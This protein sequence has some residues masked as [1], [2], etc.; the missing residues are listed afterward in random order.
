MAFDTNISLPSI[1]P[2]IHYVPQREY[3]VSRATGEFPACRFEF[4]YT[5][6]E[7]FWARDAL[8]AN[9]ASMR[10]RD[11]PILV[12]GT[13]IQIRFEVRGTWINPALCTHDVISGLA[14]LR[15]AT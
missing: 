3:H 4:E 10:G 13:A 1:R 6:G 7:P 8:E 15:T 11:D 9:F 14:T 5:T 2:L 12:E